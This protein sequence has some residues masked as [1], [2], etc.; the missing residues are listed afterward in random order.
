MRFLI[1]TNIIIPLEPATAADECL[2]TNCCVD[3]HRTLIDAG[4]SIIVHPASRD[5]ISHDKDL[6]RRRFREIHFSKYPILEDAPAPSKRVESIIGIA[7]KNSNDWIDNQ[8]LSAIVEDAVDFLVSED[9]GIRSKARKLG[10]KARVLTID[11]AYTLLNNL[12]DR[13]PSPPPSVLATKAYK[14]KLDDPILNSFRE[15]YDDFDLWFSKCRREHRQSWIIPG[16]G[17]N[18]AGFCIVNQ[19]KDPPKELGKKI[20]KL[21]SFKVSDGFNGFYYGELLLRVAF[22]Y[23]ENNDY[24]W[25]FLTVFEKHY[26]LIELLTDFGFAPLDSRT[27]LGELILVKPMVPPKSRE[28][29]DPIDYCIKYG[30]FCFCEDVD[31]FSVPIRPIYSNILFPETVYQQSLFQGIFPFGN[32][33]RK[34]YLS[35]STISD[36][37]NGSVLAFYRSQIHRGLIAIGIVEETMRSSCPDTI[38]KFVG[39]RSVYPLGDIRK[40]CKKQV[41][42]I[43]FRQ[44][45]GFHPEKSVNGLI[46][47]DVFRQPPQTITSIS[48]KGIQCLKAMLT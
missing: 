19:E 44:A 9:K 18:V 23:A 3:F 32:S 29:I 12:S 21:C 5:D 41:F 31:W 46:A 7:D 34:A 42:A 10:I 39:K 24:E 22:Q 35:H 17:E 16:E 43:L 38:A 15:D 28:D 13:L 20:L 33:I 1:D 4:H 14:I 37:P 36:L 47:G 8:L 26:K 11:E 30:P 27:N 6:S 45:R 2:N 48:K 40:M 25:I